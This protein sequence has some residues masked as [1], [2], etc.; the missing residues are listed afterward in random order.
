MSVLLKPY[1]EYKPSGLPWL[2]AIPTQWSVRRAKF[3]FRPI[4]V[5]SKLGE[6]E[7]LTVSSS[8]GVVRRSEKAVTMFKAESYAGY[9]LCWP[10]DLVINSLWAWM[11]GLGFSLHHGIVSSAYGVYRPNSNFANIWPYFDY[12]LRS[13]VYDWEFR[14][15]SKGIW[16]SRLQLT[17]E[18]FFDMPIVVPSSIDAACI[19]RFLRHQ[20]R[21]IRRLIRR[22]RREIELLNEAR[23]AEF[24]DVL[25]GRV[26]G[27][28]ETGN[29]WFPRVPAGWNVVPL[30]RVIHSAIDGPHFSPSY[31]DSGI[32]FI[33]ARNVKVDRWS[34]SDAKYI[35][36]ADYNQF[37]KRVV[38]RLG[39][40]LY[41][42]GGTT[43]IARVVDLEFPFQ[44]WVHI[45]VLKPKRD[46]VLPHY[47][48][49]ALNSLRCYEQSQLYTRGAT[50]QDLGL[51]RMKAIVLPVPTSLSEQESAV[52]EANARI[53]PIQ[54]SIAQAERQIQLIREYRTRLTV[55]VVTGKLDVRRTQVPK[56]E[57][58]ED[59]EHLETEPTEDEEPQ[60]EMI[61]EGEGDATD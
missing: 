20:D 42:K 51:N 22:K 18:S 15:R 9:K 21:I 40:V 29:F 57:A 3:V 5:R 11:R 50:N 41:T 36:E 60:E 39:D 8:E 10:G 56:I 14:V 16:I 48:A 27:S 2:D 6:E 12:A 13:H 38:P 52:R 55:D 23:A 24:H 43:G 44:V 35:S 25:T 54:R 1:P 61:T 26:E 37:C 47:L 33:S 32:P 4:D 7:L 45:A 58:A 49:M 28:Q 46:V 17:D 34:L 19:S 59:L 30:R 31:Q 53:E